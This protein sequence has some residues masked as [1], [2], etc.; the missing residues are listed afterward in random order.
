MDFLF[1]KSVLR[2]SNYPYLSRV[3][4]SQHFNIFEIKMYF[5]IDVIQIT[6]VI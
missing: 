3:D 2:T 1:M 4:I 6:V 5:I